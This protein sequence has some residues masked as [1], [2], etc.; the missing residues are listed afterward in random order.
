MKTSSVTVSKAISRY[1]H[2]PVVDLSIVSR[3]DFVRHYKASI[4]L[5]TET[6][7]Y[8]DNAAQIARALDRPLRTIQHYVNGD[9]RANKRRFIK[10]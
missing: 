1:L 2:K 5:D 8:Y 6:G 3:M 10:T 7:I 4:I 9:R